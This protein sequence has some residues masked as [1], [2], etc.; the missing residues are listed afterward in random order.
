MAE[1]VSMTR[2]QPQLARQHRARA[3]KRPRLGEGIVDNAASTAGGTAE[4]ER[5]TR[6][7]LATEAYISL[8]VR[9]YQT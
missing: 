9:R 7:R 1:R 6:G 4:A 8:S 5:A 2:R 3:A